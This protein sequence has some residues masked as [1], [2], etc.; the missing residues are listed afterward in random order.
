MRLLE[1]LRRA[2]E[3]YLAGECRGQP[4]FDFM[5]LSDWELFLAAAQGDKALAEEASD[6]V[7]KVSGERDGF[8]MLVERSEPTLE[9]IEPGSSA[10]WLVHRPKPQVAALLGKA[11]ALAQ[12]VENG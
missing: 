10:K 9:P 6:F 11:C 8:L 12:R 1:T 4:Y 2:R 5:P 7:D 3:I